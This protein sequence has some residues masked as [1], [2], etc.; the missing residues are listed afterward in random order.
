MSTRYHINGDKVSKCTAQQGRC[1][2]GQTEQQ[3]KENHFDDPFTARKA[4]EERLSKEYAGDNAPAVSKGKNYSSA[5]LADSGADPKQVREAL[6][7]ENPEWGHA[8]VHAVQKSMMD[9]RARKGEPPKVTPDTAKELSNRF[10]EL[11]N[12]RRD[13]AEASND[14]ERAQGEKTA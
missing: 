7:D 5:D 3:E 9:N 11:T 14:E 8:R 13:V 12:A 10:A 2:Y 1:P 6:R 4:L